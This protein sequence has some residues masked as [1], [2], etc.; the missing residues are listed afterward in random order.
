[1]QKN[2]IIWTVRTHK[3]IRSFLNL[4]FCTTKRTNEQLTYANKQLI[5]I[6]LLFKFAKKTKKRNFLQKGIKKAKK[7]FQKKQKSGQSGTRTPHLAHAKRALLPDELTARE[8]IGRPFGR[9]SQPLRFFLAL[10]LFRTRTIIFL[11]QFDNE[12][13]H[14]K[15]S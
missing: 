6:F 14:A 12:N 3:I 9:S 7:K 4:E 11:F 5:I 2:K 13:I 10:L 15:L 1:M 8:S